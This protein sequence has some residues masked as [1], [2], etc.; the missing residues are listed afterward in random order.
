MYAANRLR[1]DSDGKRRPHTSVEKKYAPCSEPHSHGAGQSITR[2]RQLDLLIVG[3]VRQLCPGTIQDALNVFV[4][5]DFP[6]RSVTE[7]KPAG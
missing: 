3:T 5:Q 2:R 7:T 6:G 4:T 1:C